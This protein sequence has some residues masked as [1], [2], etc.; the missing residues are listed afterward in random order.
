MYG[1]PFATRKQTPDFV[2]LSRKGFE[3]MKGMDRHYEW[4]AGDKPYQHNNNN[5]PSSSV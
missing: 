4:M 2:L 1:W 3:M 5:V